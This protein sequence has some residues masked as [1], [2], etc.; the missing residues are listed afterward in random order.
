MPARIDE[1]L[2]GE[3]EALIALSIERQPA[4]TEAALRVRPRR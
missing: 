2:F 4:I 1:S 3:L